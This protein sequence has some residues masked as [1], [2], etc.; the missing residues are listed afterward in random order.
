MV[1]ACGVFG[2]AIA[3]TSSSLI[4]KLK[5]LA[6][7]E[8]KYTAWIGGTILAGLGSFQ[9]IWV[10]HEDYQEAGPQIIHRKC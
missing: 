1:I 7:S 3:T 9:Y 8:R 4:P 10:K 5:I 2:I 6:Q